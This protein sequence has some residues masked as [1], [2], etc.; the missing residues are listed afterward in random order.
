MVGITKRIKFC[1]S[2][3]EKLLNK[4]NLSSLAQ[5]TPIFLV[6]IDTFVKNNLK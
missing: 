4:W 2:K 1:L 5:Q 3:G 6:E